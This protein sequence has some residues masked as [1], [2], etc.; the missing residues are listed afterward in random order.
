MSESSFSPTTNRALLAVL[1]IVIAGYL[2]AAALHAPQRGA[3]LI[4]AGAQ[5]LVPHGV[6][7][8]HPP[9]WMVTPFVLLLGAIAVL[10]LIPA[11]SSEVEQLKAGMNSLNISV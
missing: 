5:E 3:E 8:N 1:A 4:V 2:I 10:P 11:T 9:Y 6:V 7:Q